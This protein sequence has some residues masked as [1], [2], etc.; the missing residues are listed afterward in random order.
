MEN[1]S[2]NYEFI[3]ELIDYSTERGLNYIE[4]FNRLLEAIGKELP[5]ELR[6]LR[7]RAYKSYLG[8]KSGTYLFFNRLDTKLENNQIYYFECVDGQYCFED[9][10][11]YNA[12]K[13]KI[14]TQ[15]RE[16]YIND[17][18]LLGKL[19]GKSETRDFKVL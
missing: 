11:Q 14:I 13:H 18:V 4:V 8:I 15:E 19:I 5:A 17:I 9:W 6:T 16:Y 12:D 2:N 7:H 10:G 3:D 1:K